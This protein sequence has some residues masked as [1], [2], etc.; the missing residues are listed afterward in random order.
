MPA[1]KKQID[2]LINSNMYWNDNELM[3]KEVNDYVSN[4]FTENE[5]EEKIKKEDEEKK[6]ESN[7]E[8]EALKKN[9]NILPEP[10]KEEKN[11]FAQ[12]RNYR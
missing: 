12:N 7:F 8:S 10:P 3:H 6:E 1:S 4:W 11:N 9:E 2:D 5:K